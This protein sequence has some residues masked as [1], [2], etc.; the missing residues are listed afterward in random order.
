MKLLATF[1]LGLAKTAR[2]RHAE[3]ILLQMGELAQ[4]IEAEGD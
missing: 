2:H 1:I 3:A 4:Q